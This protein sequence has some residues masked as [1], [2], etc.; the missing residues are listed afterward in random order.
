MIGYPQGLGDAVGRLYFGDNLDALSAHIDDE[1][2]DLIYLDPPFNSKAQYNVLFKSPEAAGS[3]AQAEAFLDAWSWGDAAEEAFDLAIRGGGGTARILTALRSSLRESDMMA[4]LVM[5]ACRLSALHRVLKRDGTLYLHCD[6]AAS[7]YLK[8]LLDATFGPDR[9]TN[10]IVWKR[11]TPKGLAFSRF[12]SNHDVIL[13]YRK[14]DKFRWNPQYAEYSAEYLERFNL[15]DE[16]TGRR[17][18]ATSLI[19]PNPDRPNLTYEF[20][21][22]TKVWRWTKERMKAAEAAGLIYFPKNGG[23]PREKRFID[24]QE[25]VPIS[26]VWTDIPAVNSRAQERIGYPTQK[27][28]ALMERIISAS[29]NPGD[30]VLDPFCGCGTTVHAA[31]H[32]ERDW[33]GMDVTH[34]AITVIE[35]R[36]GKA[37]P[38]VSIPVEGRPRDLGGARELARRNKY[39]FQWWA[40]WLFG[41]SSYRTKKG[42]DGGI[43]GEIY[44]K[45]GPR[46]IGR[47]IIS[48]KGEKKTGVSAVRE[49]A[50]VLDDEKAELGVLVTLSDPTP[51]MVARAASAGFVTT[52]HGK[53]RKLQ[54]A[55]ITEIFA[56]RKP[57]LPVLAPIDQL[58]APRARKK[59]KNE[60]QMEFTFSFVGGAAARDPQ[61]GE[62]AALNPK[63]VADVVPAPA[64]PIGSETRRRRR[65]KS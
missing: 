4:Y 38:Q 51:D 48:V 39:Q 29:T 26:S 53:F 10:E 14:S 13:M 7:H 24:E 58:R 60:G 36:M 12:A 15:I 23:V 18:Q 32:L 3:T 43:D 54:L 65:A 52:A 42:A 21:G 19:N 37:F 57:V 27:P 2:V 33:I 40:N 25:G 59:K 11:T 5:M 17:F 63:Y 34:H 20:G 47:I 16:N 44:F 56:D 28:L 8:V 22:H 9:F 49:L 41:V 50:S 62:I 1:S 6:P 55:P 64:E 45:N 61:P 46:G 35:D 31:Q 30:T